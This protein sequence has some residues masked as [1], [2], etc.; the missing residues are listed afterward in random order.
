M[1]A[2][3]L[4]QKDV[5]TGMREELRDASP[6]GSV[7]V[8]WIARCDA[9][10]RIVETGAAAR[11]T[12]DMV[13]A[14]FPHM[15]KGDAVVHNHP[16]GDL[17]PSGAD[18]NI[19]SR[20]GNAGI[21]FLII[22][23]ECSEVNVVA[24]PI[25]RKET[26]P[27]D[28][29]HLAAVLEPGG[30]LSNEMT[31]Y[32][33]RWEQVDLLRMI[34]GAFNGENPVIAEAGTG[35]G[36]SFAYLLPALQWAADNDERVVVSTATIA[37]QQQLME[38][39]IPLA[40]S[41]LGLKVKT[42]L[43][44]GRG[45]YLCL[46]RL[47][48]SAQDEELFSSGDGLDGIRSWAGE[49]TTGSRADLPFNPDE[50]AWA[51]VRCE[52]DACP[53]AFCPQFDLCFLM[54]ARRQAADSSLLVSNHHLLFSDLAAR[55]EGAA[56]D[57]TVVLPA[58]RRIILDEAHHAES[59]ATSLFTRTISLPGL[60]RLFNRLH[61]KKGR[62]S[63]GLTR[64]LSAA[65]P[66]E[67]D[68]F[69]GE[70]PNLLEQARGRAETLDALSRDLLAGSSTLRLFGE[71]SELEKTRLH[72]P[73]S[74]LMKSLSE[75]SGV[76]AEAV[77]K[78]EEQSPEPEIEGL[79]VE[80]KQT[81]AGLQ[82]ST[83]VCDAFLNRQEYG[84]EVFWIESRRRSDGNEWMEFH[85]TPLTVSRLMEE[86]VWEPFG[87]VVGTSATLALGGS[88]DHWKSRVGAQGLGSRLSEGL[89]PSPF[90][91]ASRVL[92]G[93]PT[94]GPSP[95]DTEAWE[96]F[97][98]S[99]VSRCLDLTG[100][101]ALVLFTSYETLRR[102]LSGVRSRLGASAPVILAQGED[103]RGRLLKRFRDLESSVLFA[104]DS[105]WEGVDVPG[106]SLSLVLITRLPFRPPTD[107]VAQARRDAVAAAGGNPFMNLTLPEAV[108]RFRQGF[109]RL[110]RRRDDHG[111]VLVLDPRIIRKQYGSLFLDALPTTSRSIGTFDA[112]MRDLEN[113]LY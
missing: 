12:P 45:N 48:E 41:L 76:L 60:N 39:D 92:L 19:A 73:A 35:V 79:S 107:P 9:E 26:V 56:P 30:T 47:A 58:Y 46:K 94:D 65:I 110:M 29:D 54:K 99:S 62:N 18:L 7:E 67:T 87:T 86:T 102:T 83:A 68:T 13:P 3:E 91:Y 78:L 106:S 23:D 14:L 50:G 113:F 61:Q 40:M 81:L 71:V 80:V 52:A 69:L 4:F 11:G 53:G 51:R 82:E 33:A 20:L 36:K 44:K 108:I 70:L 32:E 74:L 37:L 34:A 111:A 105:F 66:G 17:R 57:E 27:L 43:V 5:L 6:A 38:K 93:I 16:G 97:L 49:T 31:D 112:L 63:G 59:S 103:D 24:A 25:P 89:F 72:G 42:A 28:I 96:A 101:H 109:G 98:I 22:N 21:G 90:D 77:R 84:D 100:G 15:E 8:L 64:R 55:R 85:K 88:F 2:E 104:T 10:G 95:E 1:K 75:A